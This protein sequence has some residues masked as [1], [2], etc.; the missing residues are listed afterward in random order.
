MRSSLLEAAVIV[1]LLALCP[2]PIA[3]QTGAPPPEKDPVKMLKEIAKDMAQVEELL[4]KAEAGQAT[5][6]AARSAIEK[7]DKLLDQAKKSETQI[8]NNLDLTIQEIRKR[9][10]ER[11][12][13]SNSQK[14]QRP[15]QRQRGDDP[16]R[17]PKYDNQP[18]D[19]RE[20]PERRRE[21]AKKKPAD[22]K[23]PQAKRERVKHPDKEGVWGRL[24]DKLFKLITNREQ[25]V[26][27]VE[28]QQHVEEYFK[29]LAESK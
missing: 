16:E 9:Q 15:R 20:R 1:G 2:G 13:K 5:A 17:D 25:T 11:K 29:R 27:P 3:A 4:L 14:Q 18:K 22:R 6:D 7:I 21:Q 24:P 10:R 23:P 19:P 12:S 28:F 26:F 8:I